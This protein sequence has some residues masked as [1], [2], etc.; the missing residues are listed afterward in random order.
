MNPK[1]ITAVVTGVIAT[2]TAILEDLNSKK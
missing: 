2:A 1:I